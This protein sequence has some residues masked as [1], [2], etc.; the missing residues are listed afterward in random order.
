MHCTIF[1]LKQRLSFSI[2]EKISEEILPHMFQV[3]FS[4]SSAFQ[5]C[6]SSNN[7]LSHLTAVFNG[8]FLFNHAYTDKN[9]TNS[10]IVIILFVT[11]SVVSQQDFSSNS[12]V[13]QECRSA[14]K[15]RG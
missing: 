1:R 7:I 9:Q 8:L 12:S 14:H 11:F 5:K 15:R 6:D 4:E 13:L 10:T 3:N 2:S